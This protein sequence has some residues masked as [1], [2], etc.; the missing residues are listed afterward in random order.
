MDRD[1]LEA[2]KQA[3]MDQCTHLF[4]GLFLAEVRK[5]IEIKVDL[6]KNYTDSG[7]DDS[8]PGMDDS[9]SPMDDSDPGMDDSD[10]GRDLLKSFREKMDKLIEDARPST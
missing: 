1:T 7:M 10:S 8:D 6:K 5:D 2:T 9:D 4:R 3:A